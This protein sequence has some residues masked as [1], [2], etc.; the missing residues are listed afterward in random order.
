M[1][2][3]SLLFLA[4]F[5]PVVL[6]LYYL[7]PKRGWR[8]AVLCIASLFFYAWGEPVCVTIMIFS[9]LMNYAAGMLMGRFARLNKPGA[10]K[11]VLVCAVVLNLLMLGVFK[12]TPLV[13]ETLQTFV[14]TLRGASTPIA[15]EIFYRLVGRAVP[16]IDQHFTVTPEGMLPIGISFY[17]FQ[18]MSYV[19]D[20]YRGDTGVQKSP[21]I[22]GTYVAL[23]PQLIAGPIVRYKDVEDQMLGRR[24]SVG[25][26]A[27]GVKL[28]TIGL[29][30][31]ILIANQV[32]LLWNRL[33]GGTGGALASWV[34]MLA[35]TLQIYFDFAGYSDMA[36]GLGRMFGFEFLKNFDYPYISRSN[37]EFWRRWHISLGTWFREYVYIPLGGNRR[38]PGRQVFNLAVVWALTGLWHGAS[39]N[40]VLWGVWHGFF[41]VMEKLFL[42]KWLKKWP[43]VLQHVYSLLIAMFGWM[44]FDFTKLPEL[45]G[46]LGT[47]FGSTGTLLSHDGGALILSYLPLLIVACV[48]S[49]PL[50]ANL[51]HKLD[52]KRWAEYADIALV[53]IALT[54]CIASLVA[55]GYNPFIYFRF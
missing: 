30:K 34:G 15:K 31:K 14:P 20:V 52:G 43:R 41:V 27:S 25:Q 10:K 54:F 40:F 33:R 46:F 19:I 11:A 32:A 51:R 12:Y 6:G 55:S 2:F 21:V 44:L 37:T 29:A 16:F 49:T 3:S 50:A 22:F 42:G 36:I 8:N 9:I 28:F 38:G 18:A 4:V 7:L 47:M 17:T 23:F 45:F 24:E 5:L 39:W 48:A 1:I 13:F 26:F 35:Y 53:L